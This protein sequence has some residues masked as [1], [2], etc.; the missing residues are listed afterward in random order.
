MKSVE[1]IPEAYYTD[2][3]EKLKEFYMVAIKILDK[4]GEKARADLCRLQL[5]NI[6]EAQEVWYI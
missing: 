6:Y 1:D 4:A 5:K 3:I 2:D